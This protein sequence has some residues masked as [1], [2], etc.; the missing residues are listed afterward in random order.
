MA[1]LQIRTTKAGMSAA[2]RQQKT[3]KTVLH[4]QKR[5]SGL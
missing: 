2:D 3:L 4:H 5:K 1:K